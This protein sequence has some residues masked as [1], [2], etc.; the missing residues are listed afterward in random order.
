MLNP[1]LDEVEDL[2]DK[3]CTLEGATGA[4]VSQAQNPSGR[5]ERDA[6]AGSTAALLTWENVQ[7]GD[8]P[9]LFRLA[10]KREYQFGSPESIAEATSAMLSVLH[11]ISVAGERAEVGAPW[12][13]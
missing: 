8:F 5:H 7:L 13:S 4:S 10:C 12:C 1:L 3:G 6:E 9:G 2:L 11:A